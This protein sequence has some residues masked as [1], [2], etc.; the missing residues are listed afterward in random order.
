MKL[1][2]PVQ[3]G[4]KT[5]RNRIVVTPHVYH[6]TLYRADADRDVD[7]YAAYMER[8]ADAVSGCSASSPS[9]S[10]R[11]TRITRSRTT[12]LASAWPGSRRSPTV[13]VRSRSCRPCTPARRRRAPGQSGPGAPGPVPIYLSA[14]RT[15]ACAL[16]PSTATAGASCPCRSRRSSAACGACTSCSSGKGDRR[17]ASRSTPA[18]ST[19]RRPTTSGITDAVVMPWMAAVAD[20]AGDLVVMDT[21][22]KCEL[23]ARFGGEV[24]SP[25]D[26]SGA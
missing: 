15:A 14:T 6:Y 11:S 13:T 22:R 5:V 18:C 23:I 19:R 9:W 7:Q 25:L 17:R 20:S 24:I 1:L 4:A 16:P 3:V 21:S 10:R 12:T 26:R 2:E 8:R